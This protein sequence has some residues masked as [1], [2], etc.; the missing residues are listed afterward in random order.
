LSGWVLGKNMDKFEPFDLKITKLTS[1]QWDRNNLAHLAEQL[2]EK[3]GK[4]RASIENRIYVCFDKAKSSATNFFRDNEDLIILSLLEIASNPYK[5]TYWLQ[6]Y[7]CW[8]SINLI[9]RRQYSASEGDYYE[10]PIGEGLREPDKAEFER[11]ILQKVARMSNIKPNP[12]A[13]AHGN[14]GQIRIDKTKIKL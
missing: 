1:Q 11:R 2:F 9:E 10:H 14:D 7:N 8:C 5:Y 6:K 13:R 3:Q 12:D 4:P